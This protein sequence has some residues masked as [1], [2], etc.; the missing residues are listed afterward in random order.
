MILIPTFSKLL[1]ICI[2]AFCRIF[3]YSVGLDSKENRQMAKLIYDWCRKAFCDLETN[4]KVISSVMDPVK[5]R[6]I[7]LRKI[8]VPHR[9][10][11]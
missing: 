8:C 4:L 2:C 7:F 1:I 9:V 10:R 11:V 6:L 3:M 5:I